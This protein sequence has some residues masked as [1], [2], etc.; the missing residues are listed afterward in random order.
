MTCPL[1]R[2]SLHDTREL[3]HSE[4][5]VLPFRKITQRLCLITRAVRT[6]LHLPH[7]RRKMRQHPLQLCQ[8]T[9]P[10]IHIPVSE[11]RCHHQVVLWT[12][13]VQRL[14]TPFPFIVIQRSARLRLDERRVMVQC[15][16]RPGAFFACGLGAGSTA[17]QGQEMQFKGR[18]RK[19]AQ[20]HIQKH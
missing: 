14:I 7:S 1:A 17:I 9:V 3:D 11:F 2:S 12:I 19:T 16:L 20:N 4:T 5:C 10:R 18:K 6:I 15:Q 8:L 13:H